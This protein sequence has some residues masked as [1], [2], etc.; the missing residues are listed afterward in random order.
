MLKYSK[1][2]VWESKKLPKNEA[3]LVRHWLTK[4][5]TLKNATNEWFKGKH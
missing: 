2:T 3:D 4:D 1:I 5:V